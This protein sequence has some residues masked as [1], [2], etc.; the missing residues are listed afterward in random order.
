MKVKL[1]WQIGIV[2]CFIFL[3]FLLLNVNDCPICQ[4]DTVIQNIRVIE[5][6]IVKNKIEA[7]DEIDNFEK[8]NKTKTAT[9]ATSTASPQIPTASDNL[10]KIEEEKKP[11]IKTEFIR[12]IRLD[13]SS[14]PP[15]V[16]KEKQINDILN[17]LKQAGSNAVFLSPWSD[18][19]ANYHSSIAS[20]NSYGQFGFVEKF[21]QEAH[22][23][24]I[25]TFAW[26]V[27]GKDNFPSQTYP[28]WFAIT[29]NGKKYYHA[30]EPGV[31]LPFA[32]LANNNYINHHLNLLREITSLAWDGWVISEPLIGWGDVY[33]DFY[34]DFSP[35]MVSLFTSQTGLS[36]LEL[37]N[38]ES[39]FY[40]KDN[41]NLYTQWI[42]L[43]A[44]IVSD[45]VAKTMAVIRNKSNKPIAITLFTE[46]GSSGRL[47]SPGSLKEWLGE[48]IYK[49]AELN[50]DYFEIQS[51]WA[52]FEYPQTPNWTSQM[53]NEFNKQINFSVP[54]LLSVQGWDVSANEFYTAI[55]TA[56]NKNIHGISTYAYHTLSENNW[57]KLREL[58]NN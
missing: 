32:S 5:D 46:P 27:I 10:E 19:L 40:Y 16:N 23:N 31:S 53:I 44:Q 51:L 57:K 48:D 25:Q 6:S 3:I 2:L 1:I 8:I 34:T 28:D 26:F 20:L 54:L 11:A 41:S 49:L 18:G 45:F 58:W 4:K 22:K 30:D 37:F 13:L 50:P 33:D 14:L 21:I 56:Q 7:E 42:N 29:K 24:N 47:V 43:R 36:P 55:Q 9:T 12:S 39:N 17:K 52:D 38:P 35:A 15:E